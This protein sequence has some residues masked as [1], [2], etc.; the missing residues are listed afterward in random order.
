[1]S[2]VFALWRVLIGR[3]GSEAFFDSVTESSLLCKHYCFTPSP[4]PIPA[5]D[6]PQYTTSPSFTNAHSRPPAHVPP[7]T[8]PCVTDG[9]VKPMI[10]YTYIHWDILIVQCVY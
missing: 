2:S 10:M 3:S 1:M 7:Y 9:P 8:H 6:C 5:D 4:I